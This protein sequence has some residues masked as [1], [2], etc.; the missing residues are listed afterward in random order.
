MLKSPRNIEAAEEKDWRL[1]MQE[2][3]NANA[4]SIYRKKL[5]FLLIL[6]KRF[7]KKFV[8]KGKKLHFQTN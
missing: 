8:L 7:Y 6:I 5:N 1:G 4:S 3:I 2:E